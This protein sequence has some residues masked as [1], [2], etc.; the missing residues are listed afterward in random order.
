MVRDP[1]DGSTAELLRGG[2][3]VLGAGVALVLGYIVI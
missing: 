3:L 2:V 1:A